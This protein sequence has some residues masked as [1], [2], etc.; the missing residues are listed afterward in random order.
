MAS[1]PTFSQINLVVADMSR[2]VA[3]YR[4]LGV[5]ID[6]PAEPPHVAVTFANGVT[7]EFDLNTSIENW[8][9]GWSGATGSNAVMGFHMDSTEQVNEVF[10]ALVAAG[11][12]A[13][14]RPFGAFWGGRYAIVDDPDGHPVG[15]MGP[16][17][18]S[19]RH[20]PPTK[21]PPA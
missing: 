10:D 17:D 15:L 21:P 3:F 9:A 16:I 8:D 20:W 5:A 11:H 13:H 1:P 12:R 6:E 2:T 18:D 7:L 14:Q 19:R 4:L